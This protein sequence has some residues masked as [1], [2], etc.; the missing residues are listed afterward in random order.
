MVKWICLLAA[1]AAL[2]QTPAAPANPA[3]AP[4]PAPAARANPAPAAPAAPA[5]AAPKP[6]PPAPVNPAPEAPT[7]APKPA[8][9]A[10]TPPLSPAE[11]MRVSIEKQ[12]AAV[13][14]QREAVRKQAE[15]AGAW[16]KPGDPPPPVSNEPVAPQ[17]ECEP[18]A[19]AIVAPLIESNAK[20]LEVQPDLLRAVMERESGFRP[21]AVSSKGAQGLMQLMPETAVELGVS[22]PFDPKESISGGARFL[23][24]LMEKYKGDLSK[25]LG[26]YNAGP[27]AVDLAG[28]IPDI[29][30]T[31]DYVD[32][33]LKKLG[34][35]RTVPPN[36]PTPKPTGN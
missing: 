35:T 10:Q 21:C 11:A 31:K 19:D 28:G 25:V 20:S 34:V 24:Q 4:K 13:E 23:K 16:L 26:A 12:R 17:A 9:A 30:E 33:I 36:D 29:Q 22:D 27:A 32:A 15:S 7:P 8:P 1:S 3:R 18:L 14:K 6:V 2:A 5:V